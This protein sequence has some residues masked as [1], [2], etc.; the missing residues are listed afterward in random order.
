MLVRKGPRWLWL[1]NFG[2]MAGLAFAP[3]ILCHQL[4]L[5]L[6]WFL[7]VARLSDLASKEKTYRVHYFTY[8]AYKPLTRVLSAQIIAG[9]ILVWALALPILI[10][11]ITGLDYLSALGVFIGGAFIVLFAVASG[12]LSGGNKLF[13]VLFFLFT[14]ANIEKMPFADYYGGQVHSPV[15]LAL[16]FGLAAI[17]ALIS[18]IGRKWELTRA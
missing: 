5:P 10:R 3:V 14:Y 17:L 4:I 2:G 12:I 13:E 6:L 11:L 1:V 16:I 8:A 15:Y 9:I 18:F 7:Q